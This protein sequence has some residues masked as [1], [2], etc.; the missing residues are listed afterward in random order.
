MRPRRAWFTANPFTTTRRRWFMHL[1]TA[2]TMA[3]MVTVTINN[4]TVTVVTI[5]TK[6]TGAKL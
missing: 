3:T 1:L 6:N 2:V 4:T 5:N